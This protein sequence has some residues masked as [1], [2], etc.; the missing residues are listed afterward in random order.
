MIF[1]I[2]MTNGDLAYAQ[3]EHGLISDVGTCSFLPDIT[4]KFE[5]QE[6]EDLQTKWY[7]W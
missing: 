5:P 3:I 4:N 1:F 7:R 2:I 6:F